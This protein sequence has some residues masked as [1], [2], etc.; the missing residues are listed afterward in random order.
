MH[1]SQKLEP[2]QQRL[3]SESAHPIYPKTVEI[4]SAKI[5]ASTSVIDL[6]KTRRGSDDRATCNITKLHHTH[7]KYTYI[8][9]YFILLALEVHIINTFFCF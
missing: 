5:C 6:I 9:I 1:L 8:V 3:L 7:Y 2:I 4:S